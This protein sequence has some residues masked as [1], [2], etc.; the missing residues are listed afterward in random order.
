MIPVRTVFGK[1]A[2]WN[3]RDLVCIAH[4][5]RIG[6]HSK[7]STTYQATSPTNAQYYEQNA[8]EKAGECIRNHHGGNECW[9][10]VAKFTVYVGTYASEKGQ[11][12]YEHST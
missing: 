4:T 2:T 7:S 6:P 10:V 1:Y 5:N 8:Y 11:D 9:A 12:L 3:N